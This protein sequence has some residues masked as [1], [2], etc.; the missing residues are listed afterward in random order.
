MRVTDARLVPELMFTIEHQHPLLDVNSR[1]SSI[2]RRCSQ[3]R[4]LPQSRRPLP[5]FDLLRPVATAVPAC[6]C[7]C[8]AGRTSHVVAQ[9]E[10]PGRWTHG[11]V[12]PGRSYPCSFGRRRCK[13]LR[14]SDGS[15]GRPHDVG[16]LRRHFGLTK[17]QTTIS[18][19]PVS[20]S[21]SG[22]ECRPGMSGLSICSRPASLLRC[23]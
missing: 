15:R 13:G 22:D 4:W 18:L 3:A 1:S 19:R 21:A 5:P 14:V 8:C 16:H 17:E 20:D 7:I 9:G 6:G 23:G 11:G 12:C 2:P 10:L